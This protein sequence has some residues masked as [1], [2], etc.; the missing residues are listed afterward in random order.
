MR[1]LTHNLLTCNVKGVTN[2]YP[3]KVEAVTVETK[4]ADFNAD[5]LRQLFPK[6]EWG[7]LT[8]GAREVCNRSIPYIWPYPHLRE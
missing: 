3:L 1:L 6:I 7:A 8:S 2:G 4:E 5:F